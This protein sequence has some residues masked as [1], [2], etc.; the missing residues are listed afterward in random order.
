[1]Y[2]I[3][4]GA[5]GWAGL[6][7]SCL[8]LDMEKGLATSF[9]TVSMRHPATTELRWAPFF[10]AAYSVIEQEQAAKW[11]ATAAVALALFVRKG[12][13]HD[14]RLAAAAPRVL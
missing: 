8:I 7:G 2:G 1:M 11:K 9:A 3:R 5:I 6:G 4:D 10:S 12:P 13:Q 14:K